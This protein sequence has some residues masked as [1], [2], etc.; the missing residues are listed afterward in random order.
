[1]HGRRAWRR[2]CLLGPRLSATICLSLSG[3][4]AST[5]AWG[6]EAG[7]GPL[8]VFSP[9]E[10]ATGGDA[11]EAGKWQPEGHWH[12]PP[13]TPSPG[14]CVEAAAALL[15]ASSAVASVFKAR[16]WGCWCRS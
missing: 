12:Q 13:L 4:V 8:L 9:R 10:E 14:T 2:K 1:M 5:P 11:L 7:E 3:P 6:G 16:K 15:T